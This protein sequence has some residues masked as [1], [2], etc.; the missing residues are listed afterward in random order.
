MESGCQCGFWLMMLLES[1]FIFASRFHTSVPLAKT[2]SFRAPWS[3]QL[4]QM[5]VRSK[6]YGLVNVPCTRGGRIVGVDKMP[7][8]VINSIAY[9][10]AIVLYTKY[11]LLKSEQQKTEEKKTN[12]QILYQLR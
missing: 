9:T 3:C 2:C 7:Q 4:Q 5:G 1:Q 11:Q 8:P 6:V 12:N 10:Q